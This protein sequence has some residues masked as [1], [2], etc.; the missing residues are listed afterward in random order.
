MN[1]KLRDSLPLFIGTFDVV[2][3]FAFH[4]LIGGFSILLGILGLALIV[5]AIIH[6]QKEKK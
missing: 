5:G 1:I 3:A 2:F 4:T 6:I